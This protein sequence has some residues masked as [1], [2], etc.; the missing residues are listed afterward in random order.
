MPPTNILDTPSEP[1]LAALLGLLES[2]GIL[3]AEE[4]AEQISAANA[5]AG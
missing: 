5:D 1:L 3:T 4:I 2:K